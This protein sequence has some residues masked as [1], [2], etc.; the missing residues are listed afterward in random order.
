MKVGR[1]TIE[2][3]NE[4]QF[5]LFDDGKINRTPVTED[6]EQPD[7]TRQNNTLVGINPLY[8][9]DGTFRILVDTGLG[10]GLDTG[11]GNTDVS[12][13]CTNLDIFDTAPDDITHV[14]LSHLHYDH[15]AGISRTDKNAITRPVFTNAAHYV[16]QK[17][18]DFA[19]QQVQQESEHSKFYRLDDFYRLYADNY[20]TL[21][22]TNEKEI[23]PGIT[24]I[25]TGGHTPGHQIVKITDR[26]ETAYFMGDLLPTAKYLNNFYAGNFDVNMVQAKKMKVKFLREAYRENAFLFFYHS[27]HTTIGQL[28]RD[29][30]KKYILKEV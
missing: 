14:I 4:G 7:L 29:E 28:D 27:V 24:V 13:I 19:I 16:Q 18:W 22:E 21:L 17:E 26:G 15:A 9:T 20:F 6:T 1:F 12:N 2:Q 5:E 11:S 30:D 3:L 8:I 23:V 10:W 25:R